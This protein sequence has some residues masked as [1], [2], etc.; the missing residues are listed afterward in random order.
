MSVSKSRFTVAKLD[1]G[2]AI[3]LTPD[4]HLIEFPSLLLPSGV[5]AGSI[6]D[7]SVAQNA[8]KEK[9]EH[10][11]FVALQNDIQNLFAVHPPATPELRV[12][13][14]TQTSVVLEWNLLDLSTAE[15]KSLS[16]YKNG[17]K[18]GKI[19]NATTT[20]TKLSGLALDTDYTFQLVL[21]TTAGT[22]KS[23]ELNV[24]THKMTNLTGLNV[25]LSNVKQEDNDMVRA[26]LA[27]IGAKP[28]HDRVKIDTTHF[29]TSRGMGDEFKKAQ[30]MNIP[31]VIPDF[32]EAC[33]AE[34]R[35]MRVGSYYL[36][37][38]PTLR[39]KRVNPAT[40]ATQTSQASNVAQSAT[41]TTTTAVAAASANNNSNDHQNDSS[42]AVETPADVTS[43]L[44]QRTTPISEETPVASAPDAASTPQDEQRTITAQVTGAVVSSAK[45][46]QNVAGEGIAKAA[47]AITGLAATANNQSESEQVLSPAEAAP[48]T[49][50]TTKEEV[51]P[52]QDAVKSVVDL[53]SQL[54]AAEPVKPDGFPPSMGRANTEEME[55]VAL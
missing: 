35:L 50:A 4:H 54:E 40:S 11:N 55:D 38:D 30:S 26:T 7:L 33:E 23:N 42:T 1:A 31:V 41:T 53:P 25:C 48:T 27:R 28:P 44:P 17:A 45:Q 15:M 9:E 43:V 51:E 22:F 19:P 12:K 5:A 29:V 39:T 6:I 3:L 47:E 21:K 18:L 52:H 37:S 49:D 14:T 8:K 13:N 46:V 34:G 36:D 10:D 24:R 20:T 16:L 32:V 2:M